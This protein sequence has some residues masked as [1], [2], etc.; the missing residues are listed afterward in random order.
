MAI[1]PTILDSIRMAT[2]RTGFSPFLDAAKRK[3]RRG[4]DDPSESVLIALWERNLVA[5]LSEL[6]DVTSLSLTELM[7]VLG[8]LEKAELIRTAG[9]DEFRLTEPGER[10]ARVIAERMAKS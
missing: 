3:R 10:T 8:E 6:V 2:K 4:S 5:S 1:R 9:P 7:K